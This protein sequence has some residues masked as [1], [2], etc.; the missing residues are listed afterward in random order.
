MVEAVANQPDP[1]I[2]PVSKLTKFKIADPQYI[3]S[4][5]PA[6]TIEEMTNTLW[7]DIG[8]HEIIS[9]VR[10]DLVDGSNTNYG[11]ISELQKLFIEFNPQTIV[12]IEDTSPFYFNQFGI[13]F[14]TY[15]PSSKSLSLSGSDL[16]L[17]YI[18]ETH[19]MFNPIEVQAN[20]DI[21]IYVS[22]IPDEYEV[23]VQS[24]TSDSIYH[25]T[26]YGGI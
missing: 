22:G 6:A 18:T 15:L 17:V 11:R 4:G 1:N 16:V 12:S 10:R 25:D 9:I 21:V 23:E 26:I 3:L 13:R 2:R 14:D 19:E 7:Q 24:I 8:G 20:G 5:D